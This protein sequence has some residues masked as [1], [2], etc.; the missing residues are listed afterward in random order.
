VSRIPFW[1]MSG[2]GNDF[3]VLNPRAAA[4]RVDDPEFVRRVCTRRLS[5]GA[6]GV[7]LVEPHDGRD[8]HVRV[9]FFN[10]DGSEFDTCGNGARC[11]ARFAF[12]TGLAPASLVMATG[13]GLWPAEV[14]GARVRLGFPPPR[15][16]RLDTALRVDGRPVA[17]H[18][19]EF[20]VPHLVVPVAALPEGPIEPEARKLRH[21]PELGPA[22]ANVNYVQVLDRSRIA[23]RTYE[24]GVEAE[25]WACGSG[26]VS[27]ALAL[28]RAGAVDPPVRVRVRS[29]AWLVVDFERT[30]DRV[31]GIV[32]E[33]DARVVYRA[34]LGPDATEWAG[35]ADSG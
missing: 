8:A 20:G 2:A 27:A 33:G 28:A 11:A 12:E 18:F 30:G 10:P 25:T 31:R 21:A 32:L 15:R 5:V 7:V 19:V 1:K 24:R 34:E 22:G 3:L 29:G 26:S 4:A 23:V 35:A 16:I 13:A 6:D 14:R 17:G 9:R